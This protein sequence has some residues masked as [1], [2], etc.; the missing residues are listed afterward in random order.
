MPPNN[1]TVADLSIDSK[2][3]ELAVERVDRLVKLMN[4]TLGEAKR[5]LSDLF[6]KSTG[7]IEQN[8]VANKQHEAQTGKSSKVL[9]NF[10]REQGLQTF[11][12][13]E[14]TQALTSMVFAL[15]FLADGQGKAGATTRKYTNSLLAGVTAMNA[16]QFS[17]F[18]IARAG[19]KLPGLFGRAATSLGKYG[20]IIGT[21]VGVGVALH[22]MFDRSAEKAE[23]AAKAQ[24]R[25]TRATEGFIAGLGPEQA[26]KELDTYNTMLETER[27][28][29]ELLEGPTQLYSTRLS[30]TTHGTKEQIEQAK[31]N[32][33]AW[34]GVRDTLKAY[35]DALEQVEA[36]ER[37]RLG[38]PEAI[39]QAEWE[40]AFER[41]QEQLE[42]YREI[43]EDVLLDD[44]DILKISRMQVD[45]GLV[46]LEQHRKLLEDE[47]AS[48]HEEEKKLELMLEIK[49]VNQAIGDIQ[50]KNTEALLA[51]FGELSRALDLI[52]LQADS[53]VQRLL[54]AIQ[55]A[56]K[57]AQTLEQ[58]K[59]GE[60]SQ[61]AGFLNILS[62]AV[63]ILSLFGG[64]QQ[65][66]YTGSGDPRK[67]AGL[68]HRRE[69]VFEQPLVDRHRDELMDLRSALREGRGMRS[70][71]GFDVQPLISEMRELRRDVRN[72]EIQSPI[73]LE[74]LLSGQKFLRREMAEYE[75]FRKKKAV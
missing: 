28:N 74:N 18:G 2:K 13:R 9:Q 64:F 67:V 15:H 1:V 19:E 6:V 69:I 62:S 35:V 41:R 21:V 32:I 22:L 52:G 12:V 26:R 51:G 3:A 70:V 68:V 4:K 31:K 38:Q 25:L 61:G 40:A 11:V 53:F 60:T 45:L 17:T 55:A 37:R 7:A 66:G 63:S 20:G 5:E 75:E 10:R 71:G 42:I 27:Q 16:A 49:K 33:A 8:T 43:N 44:I 58:I 14:G 59:I 36:V 30:R 48:T 72:L 73:I 54:Q 46:S 47:L 50:Q 56:I 29:L 39:A 34:G 24:E 65:G 57:L 23:T